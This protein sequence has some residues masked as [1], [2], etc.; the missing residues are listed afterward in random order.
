M[1]SLSKEI[2]AQTLANQI[3]LERRSSARTSIL[4]EGGT[5]SRYF[6]RFIDPDAASL[7][8]C[9]DRE[10]VLLTLHILHTRGLTGV[11]AII[12]RDYY[13]FREDEELDFDNVCLSDHNDLEATL[14]PAVLVKILNEYGTHERF[15]GDFE[16]SPGRPFEILVSEASKIGAVRVISHRDKLG[17][18]FNGMKYKFVSN[19]SIEIDLTETLRHLIGR[20]DLP[21]GAILEGAVNDLLSSVTPVQALCNGHDLVRILGRALRRRWGSDSKFDGEDGVAPL[22]KIIRVAHEKNDFERTKLFMCMREW[23]N[24]NA[25]WRVFP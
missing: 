3:F 7:T 21:S 17:V 23:E 13:E 22:E 4:V 20:S 25:P 15:T 6:R 9:H 12:D 18:N 5:D 11:L 19:T 1:S 2:S 8:V 14:L 24:R 16:T 10:R